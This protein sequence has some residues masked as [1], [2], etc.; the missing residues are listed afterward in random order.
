LW[1]P[2]LIPEEEVPTYPY[3]CHEDGEVAVDERVGVAHAVEAHLPL[4][5]RE[6]G[7]NLGNKGRSRGGKGDRRGEEQLSQRLM[8][9][10]VL[11]TYAE[12]R[13][14]STAKDAKCVIV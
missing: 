11:R 10:G 6:N 8:G 12:S 5:G 4:A 2:H 1:R 9:Y 14:P 13:I 3:G 7:E